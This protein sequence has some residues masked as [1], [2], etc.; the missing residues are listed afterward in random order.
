MIR[1][2]LK[3]IWNRKGQHAFLM[4]EVLVVFVILYAV[5]VFV[6]FN[7]DRYR[8]PLGFDTEHVWLVYFNLPPGTD[9]LTVIDTKKQL[10]TSMQNLPEIEAVAFSGGITPFSGSNWISSN[11]D[12]GFELRSWMADS[13]DQLPEVLG[14]KMNAGRWFS[15]SDY[16]DKYTPIVVNQLFV[17]RYFPDSSMVG[18]VIRFDGEKRIM[19][20]V[21]HYKYLGEFSEEN[22]IILTPY[23]SWYSE[24]LTMLLRVKPGTDAS[25]EETISK[26]TGNIAR[27]WDFSIQSMETRRQRDSQEV[28]APIVALLTIC[29]FLVINVA[30][31]LFGVLMYNINRRRP[32]IGLRLAMG[33][34]P[35][36][37]VRQFFAE[38]LLITF[39]GLSLGIFFAA[40]FPLL[41][42]AEIPT[43]IYL[44][45]G[46]L[47]LGLIF[48]LVA[49]CTLY[50]SYVASR[51]QP[52][53]ALHEE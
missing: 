37:I 10:K 22:P 3:L 2:L 5:T 17:D 15:E 31:G 29:G 50:P 18:K 48:G 42:I 46:A 41:G 40:Q 25:L 47:S 7:L 8:Q 35:A 28:W 43:R 23:F 11:N 1:H 14:L 52:A 49:L 26:Q 44:I 24:G 13:D 30:L 20:V 32:E 36:R 19:G 38:L 21:D 45:S 33:A 53:V 12:M 34:S 9:S 27:G 51:I 39:L 4:L 16:T 6:T